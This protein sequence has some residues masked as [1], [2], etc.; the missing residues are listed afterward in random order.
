MEGH[1]LAADARRDRQPLSR[2]YA[3][4]VSGRAYRS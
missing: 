1:L 4:L 3:L 2:S